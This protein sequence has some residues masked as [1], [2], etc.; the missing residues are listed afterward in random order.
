MMEN[1]DGL[2]DLSKKKKSG[3]MP[4]KATKSKPE[5]SSQLV[6]SDFHTRNDI[7]AILWYRTLHQQARL[8]CN[9]QKNNN[10]S[11]SVTHRFTPWIH[12][13]WLEPCNNGQI[14][15]DTRIINWVYQ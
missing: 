5:N 6:H 4:N 9:R 11:L 10:V 13:E 7:L 3:N 1:Y 14:I 8:Q 15:I 12:M 2:S